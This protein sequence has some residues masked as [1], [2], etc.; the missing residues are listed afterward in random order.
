MSM[1][2]NEKLTLVELQKAIHLELDKGKTADLKEVNRLTEL[3]IKTADAEKTDAAKEAKD[4]DAAATEVAELKKKIEELESKGINPT[5]ARLHTLNGGKTLTITTK[6]NDGENTQHYKLKL[7]FSTSLFSIPKYGNFKA[8][9]VLNDP[10]KHAHVL[11]H[12]IKRRSPIVIIENK[13]PV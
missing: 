12:L 8:M 9:D 5:E 7:R 1:K 2:K 10:E 3:I 4:K 11:D 6:E 13:T